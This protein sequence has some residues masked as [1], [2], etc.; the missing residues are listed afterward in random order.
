MYWSVKR[1]LSYNRLFNFAVGARRIGKTYSVKEKCIHD[2]LNKGHHFIYLRRFESELRKLPR[3]F[4]DV[5]KEFPG[6]DFKVDGH[7][8]YI[9]G[10]KC[11]E[12]MYLSNQKV[13]KGFPFPEV[14]NIIFDEFIIDVGFHHYL[15][16]EVTYF[17][18]FYYSTASLRDVPVFFLSN[19][20]TITNP[21]FSYFEIKAP[22]PGNFYAKGEIVV[23]MCDSREFKK[24]VQEKRFYDLIKGSQYERYALDNEFL[25]DS[26]TFIEA[27]T[28]KAVCRFVIAYK[29]KKYGVW[30]SLDFDRVWVSNDYDKNCF[31]VF[32]FSNAEHEPNTRLIKRSSK[33]GM[34][35]N[36][37][38]DFEDGYVY[39]ESINIKNNI[40]DL[41]GRRF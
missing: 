25:R 32:V 4:N 17:L 16:D 29:G 36:F 21:Y 14:W 40:F 5:C 8:F 19:A 13:A 9:D 34:F 38:L 3:F 28:G 24:H 6:H 12:A 27:K 15:P 7:I 31:N 20:I 26:N 10:K 37:I 30:E 41:L 1:L 35:K 18:E 11:G 39:F 2:F 33:Q 23:E 22:Q